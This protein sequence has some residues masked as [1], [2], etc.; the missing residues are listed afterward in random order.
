MLRARYVLVTTAA[1]TLATYLTIFAVLS[2]YAFEN[3]LFS[4]GLNL[5]RFV[6]RDRSSNWARCGGF[7]LGDWVAEGDSGR[8]WRLVMP[9]TCEVD[10]RGG[11]A[12]WRG[13]KRGF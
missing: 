7:C 6:M 5:P 4:R 8:V 3:L 2:C 10:G 13:S 9:S 11:I 12:S 1:V